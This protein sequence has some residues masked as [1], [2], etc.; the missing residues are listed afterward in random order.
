MIPGNLSE[1]A[2][3]DFR[4]I[5]RD[6]RDYGPQAS[7]ELQSRLLHR[8]RMIGQGRG[9]GH[10]RTDADYDSSVRFVRVRPYPFV[11]IYGADSRIV[12]RIVHGAQNFRALDL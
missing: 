6:S 2:I 3:R 10:R 12:L 8:F 7:R 9:L 4:K 1:V 11:V 5:L